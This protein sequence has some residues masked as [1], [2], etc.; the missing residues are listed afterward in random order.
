MMLD[1]IN[2]DTELAKELAA[3]EADGVTAP[4]MATFTVVVAPASCALVVG[5]AYVTGRVAGNR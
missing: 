3:R 4:V 1:K 5:A 2:Q